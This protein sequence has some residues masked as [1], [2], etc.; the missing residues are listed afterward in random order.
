M[1]HS[2]N[3][4]I[5]YP[6]EPNNQTPKL[7]IKKNRQAP[8]KAPD[9]LFNKVSEKYFDTKPIIITLPQVKKV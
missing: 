6:Y 9:I 2:K 8:I 3:P 1:K 5:V 4:F 7:V